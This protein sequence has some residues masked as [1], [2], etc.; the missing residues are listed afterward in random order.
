MRIARLGIALGA[1]ACAAACDASLAAVWLVDA[2]A[3]DIPTDGSTAV[4][5]DGGVTPSPELDALVEADAANPAEEEFHVAG[6]QPGDIGL[7]T[8]LSPNGCGGCHY[9]NAG[10]PYPS[11][12]GSLMA[13]AARDPLFYAQLATAN[14]DVPGVGRYCIRCH[15]PM[16]VVTGSA[17]VGTESAMTMTDRDGVSCHFCHAMIDPLAG[18]AGAA[19]PG[20]PKVLAHLADP[21]TAYGNAAFVLDPAWLRRGPYADA[22]PPHAATVSP[23]VKRSEMCGTCHDVGNLRVTRAPDGT[24]GYV[25]AGQRAPKPDPTQQFPLER[26]FTEWRLSA[27]A[28]GGVDMHGVFGGDAGSSVVSTCQDCHMPR[29]R[30]PA[31]IFA[32]PR[33]ELATHEFAGASAWVL[34]I[35]ADYYGP[36]VDGAALARGQANAVAMLERAATLALTATG[37]V[38]RARVTNQ[39]G[40]KIPTGHIEGRRIWVNV[41]FVDGAGATLQEHGRWDPATGELDEA[42]TTVFEMKVGLSPAAS[43]VTGLEAGVTTHMALADT[44]VK[45]S[46]IPPLGFDNA[47]YD[48][49]GA[50]AVGATYADGQNWAD[51]TFPVPT[52]AVRAKVQVLYQ[53]VTRE[54]IE[55]LRT[56]NH[57]D[58]W[59]QALADLWEKSGKA[60]PIPIVGAEVSF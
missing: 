51:I 6:T 55:A 5:L 49:L 2:S 44:V 53:T 43:A 17:N 40:H 9:G 34:G 46:R 7:G 60:A 20:D 1:T 57:T 13:S 3:P 56:G 45:D 30:A 58:A 35:V 27:F 25:P 11:F 29:V 22:A 16:S 38:L 26:T 10:A 12:S 15:A 32:G 23:F 28:D 18:D 47:R 21:P 39:S 19:S 36:A 48:A 52:G 4:I 33:A 14:Q 50:G 37:G 41:V 31:C 59:G 42:S 8:Y 54:Y 24:Y